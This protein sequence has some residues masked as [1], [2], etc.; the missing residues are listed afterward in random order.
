MNCFTYAILT[1]YL[2]KIIEFPCTAIERTGYSAAYAY[3]YSQSKILIALCSLVSELNF[4]FI[5]NML[6]NL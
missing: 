4:S 2:Q 5:Q 6:K 1:K 3:S